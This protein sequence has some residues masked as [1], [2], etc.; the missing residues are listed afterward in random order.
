MNITHPPAPVARQSRNHQ[1][2]KATVP[3]KREDEILWRLSFKIISWVS[4]TGFGLVSVGLLIGFASH[5]E[6]GMAIGV[7]V[8]LFVIALI[9]RIMRSR[10]ALSSVTVTVINPLMTHTVPYNSIIE[11][12]GGN[13]GTLNLVTREGKEI[14]STAFGGSVIDTFVGSANRAAERIEWHMKKR[15][16][17]AVPPPFSTR[18]TISPVADACFFI[19]L[20]FAIIGGILGF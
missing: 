1:K 8:S 12:R 13:G 5:P 3:K 17:G 19:A 6:G 15:R 4:T 10:I 7:A 18:F 20:V 9:R 14:Y 2:G 16:K 11:V